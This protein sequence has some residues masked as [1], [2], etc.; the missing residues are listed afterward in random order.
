MNNMFFFNI[1]HSLTMDDEQYLENICTII[2]DSMINRVN[3]FEQAII[4]NDKVND[5]YELNNLILQRHFLIKRFEEI[6]L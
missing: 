4:K 6:N 3:E 1:T 5:L 2:E